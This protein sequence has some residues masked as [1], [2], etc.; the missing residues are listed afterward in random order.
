[1]KHRKLFILLLAALLLQ[2]TVPL[3]TI[4]FEESFL[5]RGILVRLPVGIVDPFD[6]LRGRYLNLDIDMAIPT[7]SHL[8]SD[9]WI[10][11]TGGPDEPCSIKSVVYEEPQGNEP[12]LKVKINRNWQIN[13]EV[14]D[15]RKY[16][17][18]LPGDPIRWYLREDLAFKAEAL[19]RDGN[20]QAGFVLE[21]SVHKGIF[22]PLGLLRGNQ[23][24]E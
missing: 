16:L 9:T 15:N 11:L 12:Y 21:G 6:P 24:F 5:A 14:A 20:G 13:D 3:L 19:L 7:V 2:L 23:A 8:D 1:M 10:T 17:V 18:M 4:A 22:R